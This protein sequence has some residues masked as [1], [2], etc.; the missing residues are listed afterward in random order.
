MH[1]LLLVVAEAGDTGADEAFA[2]TLAGH[3]PNPSGFFEE[4]T[5]NGLHRIP[6]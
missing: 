1:Q 4:I 3:L 5:E 2:T 6:G